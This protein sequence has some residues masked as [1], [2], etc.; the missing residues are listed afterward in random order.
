[1]NTINKGLRR[2][3]GRYMALG[4][5]LCSIVF[6]ASA[7]LKP[8][9]LMQRAERVL[10]GVGSSVADFTSTYYGPKGE[11]QSSLKG[12]MTLQGESFRLEYGAITAVYAGGTLTYYNADES[13]LT[14]SEPTQEELL[15]INPLHFLRSRGKSYKVEALPASK[16]AEILSFTPKTKREM[17]RLEVSF[18]RSTSMPQEAVVIGKDGSRLVV[19]IADLKHQSLMP[20]AYFTLSAKQFPG[21]EVVDM[22]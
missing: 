22:R 9:E 5:L 2:G 20:S 4:V 15:Q 6:G 21:C 7:Q 8:N 10:Y 13:T 1:M 19:R 12:R 18:L 11:E 14:I 3:L 17:K 16:V